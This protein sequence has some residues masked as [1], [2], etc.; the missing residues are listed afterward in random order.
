M[1]ALMA[2]RASTLTHQA[3]ECWRVSATA[4]GVTDLRLTYRIDAYPARSMNVQRYGFTVTDCG[5]LFPWR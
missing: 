3:G 5:L 4:L 1:N 2:K